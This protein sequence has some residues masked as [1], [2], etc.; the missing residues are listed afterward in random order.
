MEEEI[1]NLQ[2]GLQGESLTDAE[3]TKLQKEAASIQ[4]DI[5][6]QQDKAKNG[7]PVP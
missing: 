6:K 5:E 3:R 4:D 1:A 7:L 2:K